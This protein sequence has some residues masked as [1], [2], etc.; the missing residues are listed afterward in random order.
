MHQ[1]A[2]RDSLYSSEVD[3]EYGP[4]IESGKQYDVAN[5]IANFQRAQTQP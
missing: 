3:V 1:T 4:K 5:L 2:S